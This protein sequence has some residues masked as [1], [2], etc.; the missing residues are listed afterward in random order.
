MLNWLPSYQTTRSVKTNSYPK[1]VDNDDDTVRKENV[2]QCHLVMHSQ[3]ELG[4]IA[5]LFEIQIA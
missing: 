1:I 3:A 4:K 2:S 5:E